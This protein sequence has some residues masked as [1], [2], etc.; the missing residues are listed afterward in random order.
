[1]SSSPRTLPLVEGGAPPRSEPIFE[2]IAVFGLGLI[3]GSLAL[4][5]RRAWP[6]SLI[7]GVDSNEV[8]EEAMRLHA[9]DVGADDPFIA[10]EADLVVLAAPVRENVRLLEVVAAH[11]QRPAVVTDVGS[12]KRAI[13]E[14]AA[15]LPPHLNFVGGHPL[16]GAARG[17]LAAARPDLFAGRP[18]VLTPT[19]EGSGPAIDQLV[20]F[21]EAL[22]AVPHVMSPAAHDRLLAFLSHLPQLAA[23]VLME[24]VG[25]AVGEE[26]L[27][28]AGRGLIDTTRLAASPA[29][30][31]RDICATNADEIRHA[32]DALIERLGELREGLASEQ[33][34]ERIFDGANRWRARLPPREPTEPR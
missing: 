11:I 30:V 13:V 1:M 28:L 9:V 5:V 20:R 4:A 29:S 2:K 32:L 16:A 17:G 22:G 12:T 18:W 31:W 15:R 34:I 26:G 23:S 33:T 19:G 8:L 27:A 7:I 14:A 3:G 24:V 25:S 21:V 10:A 6:R